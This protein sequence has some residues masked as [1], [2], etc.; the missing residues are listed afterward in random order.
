VHQALELQRI[1]VA[2]PSKMPNAI[3]NAE[4][5]SNNMHIF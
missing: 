1:K 5:R 2:A 4:I 3:L